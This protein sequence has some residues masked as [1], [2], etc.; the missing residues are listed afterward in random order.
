[1]DIRPEI[2]IPVPDGLEGPELVRWL[3]AKYHGLLTPEG[4][5]RHTYSKDEE[6]PRG[7][8]FPEKKQKKGL[9]F[10]LDLQKDKDD[11]DAQ[12]GRK[13]KGGDDE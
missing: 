3:H 1:M 6:A 5:N 7:F 4:L 9:D 8:F 13:P 10:D 2:E 11:E 12:E